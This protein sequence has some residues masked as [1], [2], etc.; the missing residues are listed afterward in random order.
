MW[1]ERELVF[2]IYFYVSDIILIL[3]CFLYNLEFDRFGIEV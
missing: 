1:K 3:Y 2:V